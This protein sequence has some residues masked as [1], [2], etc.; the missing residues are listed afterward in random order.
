[1]EAGIKQAQAVGSGLSSYQFRLIALLVAPGAGACTP[2]A[3]WF[4]CNGRTASH[5]QVL[6][7]RWIH[8]A[9]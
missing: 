6:W 8:V 9:G 7:L 2:K 4:V 1:V 3:S 5:R